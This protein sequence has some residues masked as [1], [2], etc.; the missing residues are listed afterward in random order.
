MKLLLQGVILAR[1][2]YWFFTDR[3]FRAWADFDGF[4][5][6]RARRRMI[7][8]RPRELTRLECL[9]VLVCT[10]INGTVMTF[11]ALLTLSPA[12]IPKL[13]AI[14]IADEERYVRERGGK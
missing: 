7:D 12:A 5:K 11:L 4:K 14:I 9:E 6:S 2:G 13:W 1:M 8:G 3:N 10:A